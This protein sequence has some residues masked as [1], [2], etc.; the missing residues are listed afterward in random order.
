LLALEGQLE[1]IYDT[2]LGEEV[3]PITP[4]D[5]SEITV[6]IQYPILQPAPDQIPHHQIEA[7]SRGTARLRKRRVKIPV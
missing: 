6:E 7:S 5:P 1:A 2:P 3:G 4:F